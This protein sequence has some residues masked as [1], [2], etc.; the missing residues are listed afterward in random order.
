MHTRSILI[1]HLEQYKGEAKSV[2]QHIPSKYSEEMPTKSTEVSILSDYGS[3]KYYAL[4]PRYH[5]E[6]SWIKMSHILDHYMTLVSVVEKEGHHILP[7]GSVLDFDD[8]RYFLLL[9][10]GDQLTVARIRGVQGLQDTQAKCM[11]R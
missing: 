10:G 9:I 8:S 4:Y 3:G 7:N 5:L 6:T 1:C 2:L 11:N